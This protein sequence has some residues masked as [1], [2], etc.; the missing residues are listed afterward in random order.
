M[1]SWQHRAREAGFALYVPFG[2]NTR[3]DL[4]IERGDELLRV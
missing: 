4:I 3:C 2:E 1:P